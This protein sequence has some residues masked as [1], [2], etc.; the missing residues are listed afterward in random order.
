MA[1]NNKCVSVSKKKKSLIAYLHL[2]ISCQVF[3]FILMVCQCGESHILHQLLKL[4]ITG[5]KISLTV[6][7]QET[8][9]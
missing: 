6:H 1:R 3:I 5:H 2:Y 4:L 9:K 8:Q 7:L